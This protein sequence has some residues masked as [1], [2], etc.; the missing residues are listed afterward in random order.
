MNIFGLKNKRKFME[1]IDH[2]FASCSSSLLAKV[3]LAAWCV[4]LFMHRRIRRQKERKM[5]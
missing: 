2:E 1:C 5:S 4:V 3:L